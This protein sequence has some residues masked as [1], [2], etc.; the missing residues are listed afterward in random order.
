MKT[1]R[2]RNSFVFLNNQNIHNPSTCPM[3][4]QKPRQMA[5]NTWGSTTE[6]RWF[7]VFMTRSFK[8]CILFL[9]SDSAIVSFESWIMIFSLVAL[10]IFVCI[11]LWNRTLLK[12]N[13]H[14]LR[15][16]LTRRKKKKTQT[17][18][19]NTHILYKFFQNCLKVTSELGSE[20]HC[21][22]TKTFSCDCIYTI[23][24]VRTPWLH[25]VFYLGPQHIQHSFHGI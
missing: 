2:R 1:V 16:N 12:L 18:M 10:C 7:I 3:R 15:H 19:Y 13:E 8:G 17:L 9:R 22:F 23:R 6:C 11:K 25:L 20:R 21:N 5:M 14:Y 24:S 4:S